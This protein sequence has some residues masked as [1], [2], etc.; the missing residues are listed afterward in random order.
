MENWRVLLYLP[1]GILPSIFFFLRFFIQW[2]KSE[3][4]KESFVDKSFWIL[5]ILGNSL[6]A[7]HYFIQLQYLFLII[8][9]SNLG[10][11]CR[12]INLINNKKSYS[13]KKAI[14]AI[15]VLLVSVSFLFFIQK[16]FFFNTFDV[17]ATPVGRVQNG[18]M[19]RVAVGWQIVG[20]IGS[21]LF[22]SRF[23]YQWWKLEKSHQSQL[24]E[25]FWK[26]S[27]YGNILIL[28]YS[29]AIQD[30]VSL[31]NYSFGMV[32]YLRNLFLL[33]RTKKVSLIT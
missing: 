28:I 6:A 9:T 21:A 4:K 30:M 2:M 24:D 17:F 27:I 22:A 31:I 15:S 33:R 29:V 5:S 12:N 13:T 26:L 10:I 14:I 19:S 23:W 16:Y 11:A 25:V 32:P 8:Q 3:K 20:M 1:L 7:I 18:E